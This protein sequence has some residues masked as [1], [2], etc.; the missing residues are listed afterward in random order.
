MSKF[1][2][3][4]SALK[5]DLLSGRYR[6]GEALPSEAALARAFGVSRMTARRALDELERE[7]FVYRVQGSGSYPTGARFRQGVFRIR[8]LEEMALG[9]GPDEV[10][11]TR[12]LQ[13]ELVRA[14]AETAS[15]L[16]LQ[17]GAAVFGLVRLRGLADGPVLLERRALRAD[18]LG[19]LRAD[20][21][22]ALRADALGTNPGADPTLFGRLQLSGESIHDALVG[23]LGVDIVRVEQ[24]L[25]A[26]GATGEEARLL[27]LPE[28]SAV[29]LMRRLSYAAD[30]PFAFARYW[31]RS[32]RGAF[33]SAFEP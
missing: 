21:L 3:I 27:E 23:Q 28:G 11:T 1:P 19:A 10:P 8:S 5:S 22:G 20:A 15:P 18:A 24:S 25:E 16:G 6:E 29:F 26:V 33:V 9:R 14:D 17:V 7:G 12:V 32:D 2:A 31:V 4:K 30:G 13:A